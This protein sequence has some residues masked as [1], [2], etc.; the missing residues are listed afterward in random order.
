MRGEQ[1]GHT[2]VVPADTGCRGASDARHF[3]Y[4]IS[5]RRVVLTA[6]REDFRELPELVLV[7]GASHPG[8]L[9][10]RYDNDPKRDMK[11]KHTVVAIH[12]LEQS[13]LVIVNEI[14]VLNQWR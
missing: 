7:S 13:G 8:A 11:P 3:Q 6:D 14:V 4:A 1:A 12:R 9:V 2:V 5:A 10:V